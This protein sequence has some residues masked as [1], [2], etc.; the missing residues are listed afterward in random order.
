[1]SEKSCSQLL[2]VSYNVKIPF[3]TFLGHI[4]FVKVSAQVVTYRSEPTF[5]SNRDVAGLRVLQE[6]F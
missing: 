1:M 6:D 2:N 4:W 5:F 3:T